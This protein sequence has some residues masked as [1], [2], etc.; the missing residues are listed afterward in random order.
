MS[1]KSYSSQ[2]LHASL[3]AF[4]LKDIEKIRKIIVCA[5]VRPVDKVIGLICKIKPELVFGIFKP[6]AELREEIG[7]SNYNS[8][9][10]AFA[11][12][13]NKNFYKRKNSKRCQKY[14]Q[15]GSVIIIS[16]ENT[17]ELIKIKKILEKIK[18]A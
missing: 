13:I 18:E 9:A 6:L 7:N 11:R 5:Y 16:N 12:N 15:D 8:E 1:V 14:F 2:E 10:D 4:L 17:N 3:I